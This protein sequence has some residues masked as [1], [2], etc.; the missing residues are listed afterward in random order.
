MGD[1][2]RPPFVIYARKKE[3]SAV[4]APD[5]ISYSILNWPKQFFFVK[6]LQD[7]YIEALVPGGISAKCKQLIIWTNT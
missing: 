4:L 2:I 7:V 6:E 1:T 3:T 5:N